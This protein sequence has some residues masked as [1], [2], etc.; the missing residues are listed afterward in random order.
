MN[1]IVDNY[2]EI[3][4]T[5]SDVLNKYTN[6]Q[7]NFTYYFH[8]NN[9]NNTYGI[10]LLPYFNVEFFNNGGSIAEIPSKFDGRVANYSFTINL[11]HEFNNITIVTNKNMV[12]NIIFIYDTYID[13]NNTSGF[14]N[15]LV[16]LSALLVNSKGNPISNQIINFYIDDTYLGSAITDKNGIAILSWLA[17][18]SGKLDIKVVLNK[19]TN[20][21]NSDNE[22]W[23]NITPSNFTIY[24]QNFTSK[25]NQYIIYNIYVL[26]SQLKH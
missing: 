17:N 14:G 25:Y 18:K 9:T 22:G 4:I 21:I 3:T 5:N 24:I 8:L 15:R 16:N 12:Y 7:F 20:Y 13:Y 10:D 23:L 11:K 6:D 19:T 1:C 2:Y 26:I